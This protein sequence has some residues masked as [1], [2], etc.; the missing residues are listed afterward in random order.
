MRI[1]AFLVRERGF[2]TLRRVTL[3]VQGE[4]LSWLE[5]PWC[6]SEHSQSELCRCS[7]GHGDSPPTPGNS[8]ALG[9][10]SPQGPAAGTASSAGVPQRW[11]PPRAASSSLD[12]CLP[13][14]NPTLLSGQTEQSLEDAGPRGQRLPP[15]S[16]PGA[17][18]AAAL[19]KLK[20]CNHLRH[21]VKQIIF[22]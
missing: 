20:A 19:P 22:M 7:W 15:A 2:D 14:A 3:P 1:F 9:T 6:P 12:S 17:G 21:P 10:A 16:E 13:P 8:L 18:R 4:G 5:K 11:Q